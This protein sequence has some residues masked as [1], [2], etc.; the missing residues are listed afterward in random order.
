M[1]EKSENSERIT[2][3]VEEMETKSLNRTLPLIPVIAEAL[4]VEEA[5]AATGYFTTFFIKIIQ[6]GDLHAEKISA[7][8]IIPKGKLIR[9]LAGK[10][11]IDI[12]YKSAFHKKML[13]ILI[14]RNT[15]NEKDDTQTG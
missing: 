15:K 8:Y 6:G 9:F 2:F 3:P 10:A 4:T 14:E 5:S 1:I 12:K 13:Q 7:H 11:G